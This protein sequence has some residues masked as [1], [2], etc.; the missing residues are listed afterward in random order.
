MLCESVCYLVDSC[1]DAYCVRVQQ[2][3]FH[4]VRRGH[5]LGDVCLDGF[6]DIHLSRSRRP[7][8][9][10]VIDGYCPLSSLPNDTGLQKVDVCAH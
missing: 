7:V 5:H 8:Q 1:C 2:Q 6:D 3:N 9:D 4:R 10:K